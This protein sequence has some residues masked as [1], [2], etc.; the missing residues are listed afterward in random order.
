MRK[1]NKNIFKRQ[2]QHL[3]VKQVLVSIKMRAFVTVH[4]GYTAYR[5]MKMRNV[6]FVC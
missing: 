1:Y 3:L 5:E 4:V 6:Y 2:L